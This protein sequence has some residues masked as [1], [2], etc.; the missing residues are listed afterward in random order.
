MVKVL[1]TIS[2]V[3]LY[4]IVTNMFMLSSGPD[5]S[6]FSNISGSVSCP[7]L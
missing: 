1:F 7:L 6:K 4:D 5:Y 3:Q 2:Q